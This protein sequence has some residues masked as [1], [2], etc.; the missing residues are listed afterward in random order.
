MQPMLLVFVWLETWVA[1]KCKTQRQ[2]TEMQFQ[3]HYASTRNHK[4]HPQSTATIYK[5]QQQIEK[6][7]TKHRMTRQ[8]TTNR[9][10][11]RQVT[12]QHNI[13]FNQNRGTSRGQASLL[14]GQRTVHLFN[15]CSVLLLCTD[16]K[17]SVLPVIQPLW[18]SDN[19]WMQGIQMWW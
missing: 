13:N 17:T 1:L 2:I 4:T 9:Q 11:Q 12:K 14:I 7:A 18:L 6:K 15:C 16:L 5:T 3:W 19:I 8:S 10:I